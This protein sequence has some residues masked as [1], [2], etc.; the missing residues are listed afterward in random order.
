MH[1]V[2]SCI[3]FEAF[4][5]LAV[6]VVPQRAAHRAGEEGRAGRAIPECEIP[7]F[8]NCA[9]LMGLSASSS[10]LFWFG[11]TVAV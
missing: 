3:V 9:A 11:Y 7:F 5:C 2:V 8:T 10:L 6:E 4:L 1:F